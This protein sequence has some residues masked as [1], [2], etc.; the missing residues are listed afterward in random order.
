MILRL[1]GNASDTGKLKIENLHNYPDELVEKLRGLL[2]TG[3]EA[4]P[5]PSRKGFYDVHN[6]TRVFFIH[7][8]PVSGNVLLLASWLKEQTTSVARASSRSGADSCASQRL[9]CRA[10]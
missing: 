4:R 1:E 7:V 6:G 5:D 8:S 10:A 3:T 2:L 9:A